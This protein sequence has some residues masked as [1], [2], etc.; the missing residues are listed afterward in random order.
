MCGRQVWKWVK[1]EI[2]AEDCCRISQ[3][4]R[5]QWASNWFCSL[6]ENVYFLMDMT[7]LLR[8]VWKGAEKW[9]HAQKAGV[10]MGQIW[11]FCRTSLQNISATA[12]PMST[13]L[14]LFSSGE[15]PLSD[16]YDCIMVQR[17][18]GPENV[19]KHAEGR[20][21]NRRKIK[22]LPNFD[23]EYLNSRYIRGFTSLE[24]DHSKQALTVVSFP[25][26]SPTPQRVAIWRVS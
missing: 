11:N 21:G 24:Q 25:C 12:D 10:E 5:I 17:V 15:C 4:W 13:K 9:K 1:Y 18:E 26:S 22:C 14:V 3:Q 6:P 7:V 19:G 23:V 8:K 16:E 20:C 2:L